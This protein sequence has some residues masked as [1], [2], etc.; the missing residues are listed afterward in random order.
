MEVKVINEGGEM[1]IRQDVAQ[2]DLDGCKPERIELV[3]AFILVIYF[4]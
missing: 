4:S 2:V 1:V 3:L